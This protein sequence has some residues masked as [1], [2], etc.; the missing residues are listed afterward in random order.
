MT[1]SRP[2]NRNVKGCRLESPRN[3]CCITDPCF[4]AIFAA[5][6]PVTNPRP[7]QL[8][9]PQKTMRW[10]HQLLWIFRS[11]S[12]QLSFSL[13]LIFHNSVFKTSSYARLV[14]KV[15]A[16]KAAFVIYTEL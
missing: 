4:S 7:S 14:L 11:W 13:Y 2:D 15:W 1:A 6:S 12:Y 3:G 16:P 9:V 10:N 8:Q 5:F